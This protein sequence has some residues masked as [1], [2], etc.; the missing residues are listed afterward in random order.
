MNKPTDEIIPRWKKPDNFRE[1]VEYFYGTNRGKEG[2][3]DTYLRFP[4]VFDDAINNKEK[5]R[6]MTSMCEKYENETLNAENAS[7]SVFAKKQTDRR[8]Q[9]LPTAITIKLLNV[10]QNMLNQK[11]VKINVNIIKNVLIYLIYTN[12]ADTDLYKKLH[13][14]LGGESTVLTFG[15][16][17][18]KRF[19]KNQKV[20]TPAQKSSCL[21]T[22]DNGFYFPIDLEYLK[23]ERMR[24]LV[25][26]S[27]NSMFP[28]G[29]MDPDLMSCSSSF[30]HVTYATPRKK[31]D[32]FN[33][34]DS[35]DIASNLTIV[36]PDLFDSVEV[37]RNQFRPHE[38]NSGIAG[39]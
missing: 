23:R 14:S 5:V 12:D 38:S 15:L 31:S 9:T 17:F 16:S 20:L 3:A 24:I 4:N 37:V 35:C 11:N 25:S 8:G 26:S 1:I 33:K 30:Q 18:I 21:S 34:I 22:A 39:K 36:T 27:Q 2:H 29:N 7:P 10:I 28:G 19:V 32:T 6:R 13:H